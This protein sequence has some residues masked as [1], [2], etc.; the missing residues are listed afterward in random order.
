MRVKQGV[1]FPDGHHISQQEIQAFEEYFGYTLPADY[2]EFLQA[3][4]G[5]RPEPSSFVVGKALRATVREF[6]PLPTPET[7]A[8]MK[9]SFDTTPRGCLTVAR[10]T[11]GILSLVIDPRSPGYGLVI[12]W[13]GRPG[14]VM[15][16]MAKSFDAFLGK[17]EQAPAPPPPREVVVAH[18]VRITTEHPP[19]PADVV[20]TFENRVGYRF[21]EDY[22]EFLLP[23]NGGKPSPGSFTFTEVPYNKGNTDEIRAFY[24]LGVDDE[25]YDL[26]DHIA[27]LEG[28][29][30]W[31]TIP[32][33]ELCFGNQ[34]LLGV[35]GD[36]RGKVYFW[37]HELEPQNP[38]DW[39]N[40]SPI[41]N[42]FDAFL[43]AL[44][45]ID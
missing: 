22:R 24:S 27:T 16:F 9:V 10:S 36:H 7:W 13:M 21:P 19:L 15:E 42:S 4:N 3:T 20:K 6:E 1:R 12:L 23:C 32:I 38:V 8:S 29:V 26:E 37:D 25:F 33:A 14:K 44:R 34:L 35:E 5:G 11:R 30:P 45:K 28:R 43:S 18:N 31:G 39:S 2:R 40:V 41:A 17:L